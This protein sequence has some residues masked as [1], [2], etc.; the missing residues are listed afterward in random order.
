MKVVATSIV[1]VLV[2]D[3]ALNHCFEI[4]A[5][6]STVATEVLDTS[7]KGQGPY[8]NW[9]YWLTMCLQAATSVVITAPVPWP[10]FLQLPCHGVAIAGPAGAR[11][12][13]AC[14][15]LLMAEPG[16]ERFK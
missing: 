7:Y 15:M 6:P 10:V 8:G 14:V 9:F 5:M 11:G 1:D 4:R 16:M 2:K 12:I 3:A 13:D